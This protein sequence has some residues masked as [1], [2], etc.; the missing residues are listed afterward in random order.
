MGRKVSG[1]KPFFK[2]AGVLSHPGA[3]PD[4]R[5][6]NL[7]VLDKDEGGGE[8][9]EEVRRALSPCL[10]GSVRWASLSAPEQSEK[11]VVEGRAV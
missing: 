10:P 5:D 11:G 1:Q 3:R 2:E 9:A 4:Y 8:A 7:K 6:M